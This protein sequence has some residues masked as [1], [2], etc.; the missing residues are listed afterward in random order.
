MS[1]STKIFLVVIC[2]ITFFAN[3]G[4][5]P[6]DIMESRNIITAREMVNDGNWHSAFQLP[7]WP[8]CGCCSR[9]SSPAG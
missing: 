7:S 6:T 9:C 4:A 5:L 1:R 3:I 2:L 8:R